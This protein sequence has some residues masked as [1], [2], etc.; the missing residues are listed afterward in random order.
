MPALKT[1]LAEGH[2]RLD[3]LELVAPRAQLVLEALGLLLQTGPLVLERL[4]DAAREVGDLLLDRA[5]LVGLALLEVGVDLLAV[6]GH[7]LA[8][9]RG[10]LLAALGA[11]GDDH[12]ARRGERDGILG[13]A[14]AELRERGLGRLSGG[15]DLLGPGGALRLEIGLG[16]CQLLVQLVLLA[17]DVGAQLVLEHGQ[18]L[19]GLAATTLGFLLDRRERPLARVLVDVGD[20]VQRE[21][22]DALEVARADVEQDAEP[23][24]RALEIPDVADRAGQLDVAHALAPD[25]AAGDLDA[26]LVADDALVADALVLAAVALPVLGRTEDALVEQ[27]VLLRLERPVVDGLGLGDLAL[28]PFPDLVRAGERDADRAEVIDLE[29]G[30]PPRR[31]LARRR[32]ADLWRAGSSRPGL[33]PAGTVIGCG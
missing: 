33:D 13:D 4:I 31:R 26:A 28:R 5:L 21:I 32:D 23:A 10:R 8:Q 2:H 18:P 9:A 11:G 20:D 27:P 22:E 17:I 19:A 29:H 25:L 3:G 1:R 24:R 15:R 7:D 14:A 30:S 6:L 16:P 12:L